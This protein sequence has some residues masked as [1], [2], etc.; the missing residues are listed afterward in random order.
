M[1]N[2]RG[3]KHVERSRGGSRSDLVVLSDAG[4]FSS[5]SSTLLKAGVRICTADL[6]VRFLERVVR[7]G[8]AKKGEQNTSRSFE[9]ENTQITKLTIELSSSYTLSVRLRTLRTM[10]IYALHWLLA[11]RD[12]VPP[13]VKFQL[14]STPPMHGCCVLH[15]WSMRWFYGH[16]FYP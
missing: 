2:I 13:L 3:S 7:I 16:I 14:E 9:I 6:L 4:C 11:P 1:I 8:W 12:E 5:F 10:H 15:A